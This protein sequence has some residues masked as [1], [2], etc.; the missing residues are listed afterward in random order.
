LALLS[1]QNKGKSFKKGPPSPKPQGGELQKDEGKE[2]YI[3]GVAFGSDVRCLTALAQIIE[4]LERSP[5][6]KNV[7]LA[8]ADENKLYT[9]PGAGFEIVCDI[10]LDNTPSPPI[11]PPH[12]PLLKG[13][14]RGITK[15]GLGVLGEEKR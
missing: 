14:E 8:S 11:N 3:T 2:L 10:N 12:P 4:R 13:G 15:G 5:L 6:F 9:Q 1:V 7:K